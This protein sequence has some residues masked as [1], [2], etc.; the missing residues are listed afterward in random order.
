MAL[1]GMRVSLDAGF[2]ELHGGIEHDARLRRPFA[3]DVILELQPA[4]GNEVVLEDGHG[5]LPVL[6]GGDEPLAE[7]RQH[8]GLIGP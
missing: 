1:V 6:A 2:A 3:G 8:V 5:E 4:D 7:V